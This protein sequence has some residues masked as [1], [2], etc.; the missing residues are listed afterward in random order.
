MLRIKMRYAQGA[1]GPVGR[2]RVVGREQG[3]VLGRQ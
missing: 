1:L 2:A 3:R